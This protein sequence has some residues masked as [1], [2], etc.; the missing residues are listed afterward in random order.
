MIDIEDFSVE[1]TIIS[2]D[3]LLPKI[4]TSNTGTLG[5][6]SYILFSSPVFAAYLSHF[7]IMV[8]NITERKKNLGQE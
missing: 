1:L 5:I 3:I 8:T 4:R 2:T 6:K 7:G